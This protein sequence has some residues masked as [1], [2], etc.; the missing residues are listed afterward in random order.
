MRLIAGLGNPGPKYA[1]HRH[2]VGYMIADALADRYGFPPFRASFQ[3]QVSEARIDGVRVVLFKP[4]T[5]MNESGRAVGA[6][7]RYFKLKPAD[8]IVMHDELDLAPGKIRVKQGGG[9]A[10]HNGLRSIDA[11]IGKEFWRLRVGIGHPGHPA[12]VS[13][14]VL[15]DF[16][17]ADIDWLMITLDAIVRAAP[18]LVSGNG[19]EFLNQVALLTR[20]PKPKRPRP[21]ETE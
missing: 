20:P 18:L 16:A 1:R 13:G 15:R 14:H 5:Y 8:V 7:M 9:A 4:T 19:P 11:H 3:G 21:T 6:A 17:K 2:N 12:R 10:G